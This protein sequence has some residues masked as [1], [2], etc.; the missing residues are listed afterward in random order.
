[1]AN[2]LYSLISSP[3]GNNLAFRSAIDNFIQTSLDTSSLLRLVFKPMSINSNTRSCFDV[4]LNTFVELFEGFDKPT[5]HIENKQKT[6]P[7]IVGDY[8]PS[9]ISAKKMIYAEM[10]GLFFGAESVCKLIDSETF[11]KRKLNKFNYM[12]IG[13]D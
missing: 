10:I 5:T 12:I 9:A 3:T 13:D 4:K 6:I 1:M 2:R 8:D 7:P 11:E